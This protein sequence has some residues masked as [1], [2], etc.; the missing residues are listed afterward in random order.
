MVLSTEQKEKEL[1][2]KRYKIISISIEKRKNEG[3]VVS[4]EMEID[5]H[6]C[7]M[8]TMKQLDFRVRR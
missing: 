7:W 6:H 8:T 2:G 5:L 3:E 4:H 1:E